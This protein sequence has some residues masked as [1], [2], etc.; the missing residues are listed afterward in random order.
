MSIAHAMSSFRPPDE[1]DEYRLIKLLGSGGMGDVYLAHDTLLARPVAVKFIGALEPDAAA[2]MQFLVE[3]R[4]AARIQHP[5]VVT[6][7]RVGELLEHP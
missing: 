7:Y 4:A 2:R 6:I 3:A 5:N 1:F